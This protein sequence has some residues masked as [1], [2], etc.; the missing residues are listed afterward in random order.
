MLAFPHSDIADI[1]FK[2]VGVQV[3]NLIIPFR[4]PHKESYVFLLANEHHLDRA[5]FMQTDLFAFRPGA[6]FEWFAL[7]PRPVG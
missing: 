3:L 1:L 6:L 4:V 5:S 7:D 2:S